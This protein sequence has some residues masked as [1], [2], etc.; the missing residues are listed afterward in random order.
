MQ[1][2]HR[3]RLIHGVLSLLLLTLL[4]GAALAQA[5]ARETI[6]FPR[7]HR[8]KQIQVSGQ[9]MLPPGTGKVAAM[10]IHHGSGGV[11][12]AREFNY[13]KEFVAMGVAAFVIDSFKPRGIVN[14]TTDQGQISLAEVTDDAVHALKILAAH[15]RLEPSKIGIVGFSKGGAV[16]IRSAMERYT[17]RILPAGLRFALHVPMYPGCETQQYLPKNSGAPMLMLLGGADSYVGVKPCTDF[18]DKLKAAGVP[19]EVKI[20][21]G[22]GHGF[23]TEGSYNLAKGEN[24][25]KCIFE[26]Q[27]DLSWKERT[28]GEVTADKQGKVNEAGRT[29]ALAACRTQGVSGGLNPAAKAQ[30][31][32]DLKAAMSKHLLGK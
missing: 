29:K 32:T 26:E 6:S 10:I 17:A 12:E 9:L 28:S 30:S 24:W 18:A 3:L 7:E 4:G 16:A 22:A 13:A 1:T 11:T 5:L 31:L 27:P 14:T 8:G 23:D 20:Y 25:S 2:L 21:P 15:P 19:I